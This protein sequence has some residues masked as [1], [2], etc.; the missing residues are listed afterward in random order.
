M[1]SSIISELIAAVVALISVMLTAWEKK[2]NRE[3]DLKIA[4]LE[5]EKKNSDLRLNLVDKIL[6]ISLLGKIQESVYEIFNETKADRFLILIA[7]NGKVNFNIVSVI[8]EQHKDSK[9]KGN[10]IGR[11]RNLE[12]DEEYKYMLKEAEIKSF[13]EIDV[14]KMDDCLLKRIYTMEGVKHSKIRHLLRLPIDDENDVLVFSSVSTHLNKK[15]NVYEK[16]I[17]LTNY[18]S[19]ILPS[20]KHIIE[21]F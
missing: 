10:A 19:V 7:I 6:D 1:D 15:F 4:N 18:N 20:I 5:R 17:F 2:K 12:I 13:I 3:K 21:E 14:E 8:Y 16:T 11:Y 9:F